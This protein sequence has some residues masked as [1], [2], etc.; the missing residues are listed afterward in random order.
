M[1]LDD[2]GHP[3]ILTGDISGLPKPQLIFHVKSTSGGSK[4]GRIKLESGPD[5]ANLHD[6]P[7]LSNPRNGEE[8]E[9]KD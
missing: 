6:H 9:V 2:G 1:D 7:E 8:L 5:S 3:N 4:K